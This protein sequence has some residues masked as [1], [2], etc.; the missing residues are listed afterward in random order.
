MDSLCE[1][2]QK[3]GGHF[4]L[5]YRHFKCWIW[6][7][8]LNN[9]MFFFLIFPGYV[10][11]CQK[12]TVQTARKLWESFK[13]CA[14]QLILQ[15]YSTI[16]IFHD[17]INMHSWSN[18]HFIS[19]VTKPPYEITETGWGEFEIIIKIFFI[20]PNERPVNGIIWFFSP[21]NMIILVVGPPS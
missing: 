4:M 21:P 2:L 15:C 11:L 19:V 8:N 17:L 18:T 12:N 16:S 14:I 10:C 1:A 5:F 13:R 6:M 9:K 7:V 3:W 20:D